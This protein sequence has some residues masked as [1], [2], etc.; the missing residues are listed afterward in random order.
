MSRASMERRTLTRCPRS[1]FLLWLRTI[2]KR[3]AP[4]YC[5]CRPYEKQHVCS[6]G[7][8][9]QLSGRM[10]MHRLQILGRSGSVAK[11]QSGPACAAC[12]SQCRWPQDSSPRRGRPPCSPETEGCRTCSPSTWRSCSWSPQMTSRLQGQQAAGSPNS[13]WWSG[14]SF[15]IKGILR[16]ALGATRKS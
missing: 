9:N 6:K 15:P 5:K 16:K 3:T 2:G 12:M 11:F 1:P 10:L 7:L 8:V 13:G 4:A 14:S